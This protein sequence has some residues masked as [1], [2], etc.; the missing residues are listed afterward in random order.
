MVIPFTNIK[1]TVK[2]PEYQL[3]LSYIKNNIQKN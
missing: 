3:L 1:V 2:H